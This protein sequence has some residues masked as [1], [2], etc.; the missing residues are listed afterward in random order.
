MRRKYGDTL[1]E[2]VAF[3]HDANERLAELEGYEGRVARLERDRV[4]AEAEESVAAAD[5]GRCR[6][7][8]AGVLAEEVQHHLRRLAMPHAAL[9]VN[10]GENDPGDEVEFLISANPGSP[11]LPLARVAS[12]GELARAM[13]ALRL[14]LSEGPETLVFDEVDAGIGGAAAAAVGRSLSA[15]SGRHQVLVV[16]HLAQVAAL[17]DAHIVV[18]KRVEGETTAASATRVTGVE[19]VDEIARMLSGDEAAESAHRHAADLLGDR[20]DPPFG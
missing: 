13:L 2:V 10:V 17:A 5:V 19:R 16:T 11:L 7:A 12:G 9:R 3:H 1:A 8:G 14:V 6:R 18:S 4:R 15:L 20:A